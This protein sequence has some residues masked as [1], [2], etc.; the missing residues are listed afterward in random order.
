MKFLLYLMWPILSFITL[1]ITAQMFRYWPALSQMEQD[2]ISISSSQSFF[3]KKI[4]KRISCLLAY[5]TTILMIQY[6]LWR[7]YCL[8]S[9]L[10]S[11]FKLTCSAIQYPTTNISLLSWWKRVSCIIW[12]H[13]ILLPYG[14]RFSH[15]SQSKIK[16]LK[17]KAIFWENPSI[18]YWLKKKEKI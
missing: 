3:S 8:I 7:F 13:H 16:S 4:T 1:I 14:D 11:F 18:L 6:L 15:Q 5:F 2:W 10:T 9:T 17:T 12:L